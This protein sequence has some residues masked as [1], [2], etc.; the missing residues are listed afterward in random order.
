MPNEGDREGKITSIMK[1]LIKL[2][3]VFTIFS[4]F[5]TGCDKND[6]S[7]NDIILGTWAEQPSNEW[8]KFTFLEDNTGFMNV[9]S[10]NGTFLETSDMF[11][12]IFDKAKMSLIIIFEDDPGSR[13]VYDV[14]T[15]DNTLILNCISGDFDDF[16]L[17]KEG[18]SGTSE[19]GN[20]GNDS[21]ACQWMDLDAMNIFSFSSDKTGAAMIVLGNGELK[22]RSFKYS[23]NKKK[24]K[25][26]ITFNDYSEPENVRFGIRLSGAA[27]TMMELTC[28][29]GNFKD[30]ILWGSGTDK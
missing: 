6:S 14:K 13:I 25:L 29:S 12:Y 9:Y 4:L 26:S 23:Y 5:V 19:L 17:Y 21:L 11:K 28:T 30:L 27:N 1:R 8:F 18:D 15:L 2:F 16:S 24:G 7:E 3:F 20:V 22:E 10:K